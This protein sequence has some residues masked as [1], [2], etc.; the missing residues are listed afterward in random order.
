MNE[1]VSVIDTDGKPSERAGEPSGI[2]VV[3]TAS[4]H[5]ISSVYFLM[6]S[7]L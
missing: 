7:G 6:C 5:L 1:K 4:L 3:I 2:I